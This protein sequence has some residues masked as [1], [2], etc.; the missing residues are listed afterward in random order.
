MTAPLALASHPP[1]RNRPRRHDELLIVDDH[2]VV[3]GG[4][5]RLLDDSDIRAVYEASDIVSAYRIFH[6]YRPGLLVTD[7][8]FRDHGLSGL[9][10]I[11]RV[12][13]LE[14]ATRILAFSMH[15]DPVIV[16]RAIEC[17]AHGFVMKDTMVA[18]FHE[19]LAA[20]RAGRCF[21]PHPLATEIAM[22][23]AGLRHAPLA[24]LTAREL[25]VLSLLGEGKT[26]EAIADSLSMSARS[27]A[28][29][30]AAL[31]Q[32]LGASSFAHL[33][34]IALSRGDRES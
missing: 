16:A 15:D 14:P 5:R 19:A 31:K 29:A 2:P 12:Q 22:I 11:R 30:I 24:S 17:G 28:A 32:K 6:R 20:V 10:L 7:L 21:L 25:Q 23:N 8:G 33:L 34:H 1:D 13:A 9:S 26:G 3:I 27:A 4:F 18:C